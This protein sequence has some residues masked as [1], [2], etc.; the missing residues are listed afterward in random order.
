MGVPIC[1]PSYPSAMDSPST[2][3]IAGSQWIRTP[4]FGPCHE[5]P[6]TPVAASPDAG[7]A[8][9]ATGVA[10]R[11]GFGSC[12]WATATV[13]KP[14][15]RSMTTLRIDRRRTLNHFGHMLPPGDRL[16]WCHSS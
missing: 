11:V 4:K 2:D 16:D 12:D 6:E 7:L 10:G 9:G 13:A 3:Q 1:N 15:E 5:D 14:V 8:G